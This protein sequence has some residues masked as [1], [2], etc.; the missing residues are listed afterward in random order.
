MRC[1]SLTASVVL[2]ALALPSAALA[3]GTPYSSPSGRAHS[4]V[5]TYDRGSIRVEA[6]QAA[7]T[8]SGGHLNVI[9]TIKVRNLTFLSQTSF[10]R[11]GR[12]VR[13]SLAAPA[14][15]ADA[16]W[17]FTLGGASEKTI[18]RKFTL[19]QPPGKVDAIEMAL[20]PSARTPPYFGTGDD[21]ELLL[22]GN[23]WRG[24]GAGA[25][26]GVTFPAGDDRAKRLSFDLPV[27]GPGSAAADLVWT[28]TSAPS[29]P[30]T[31]GKCN[32]LTDCTTSLLAPA[33]SRSG[34][35]KYGNRWDLKNDG[36]AAITLAVNDLDGTPLISAALPW[37][38]KP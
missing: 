7:V 10:V 36:H 2:A 15:K 32:M 30:T 29:A 38:S 3:S 12:C 24:V 17:S 4:R 22:R 8:R 35:Q 21:A 18:V 1:S 13:G 37:P 25:T 23:A 28:G 27:V 33:R 14:C 16:L 9:A 11:T 31:I 34:G 19:S 6:F 5:V 26:Y 20:Q